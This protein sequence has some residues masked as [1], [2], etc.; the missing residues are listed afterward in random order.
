MLLQESNLKTQPS[1]I[2]EGLVAPFGITKPEKPTM[3]K[4][5]IGYWLYF[6]PWYHIRVFFASRYVRRWFCT[7]LFCVWLTT[8]S[9]T[10]IITIDN[11]KMHK[12]QEKYVLLREFARSN[13]DW[14]DKADYIEFLYTD[15]EEH[16][17]EIENLWE[18][19]RKRL[20]Q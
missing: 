12:V 3:W 2:H 18:Q 16:K 7:I 6:L 17:K 10:C 14:A 4:N 11:A 1:P 9:L 19:R 8:V 20:G 13:S 5:M 15:E